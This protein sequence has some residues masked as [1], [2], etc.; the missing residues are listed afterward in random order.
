MRRIILITIVVIVIVIGIVIV[1]IV[2]ATVIII[3][4]SVSIIIHHHH[5]HSQYQL[6]HMPKTNSK[7]KGDMGSVASILD[8]SS[9]RLGSED[10]PEVWGF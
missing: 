7:P 10:G 2:I 8:L 4:I 1:V 6:S 5:H 9:R 3:V